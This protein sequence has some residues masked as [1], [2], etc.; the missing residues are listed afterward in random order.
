MSVTVHPSAIDEMVAR[1]DHL[2]DLR[3]RLESELVALE[4]GLKVAGVLDGRGRPVSERTHTEA[5]AREAHRR[6]ARG[7]RGE[8][9]QAGERQYQREIKRS[10]RARRSVA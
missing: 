3:R 9:V 2:L 7:E 1:R 4:R 8:W 6:W 5:D 10:E